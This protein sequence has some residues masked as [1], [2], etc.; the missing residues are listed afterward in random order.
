MKTGAKYVFGHHAQWHRIAL[1]TDVE[2]VRHLS[3]L[4]GWMSPGEMKLFA[5]SDLDAA[6]EWVA[7]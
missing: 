6:K 1:V 4:F 7:G 3:G 2:W 5:L